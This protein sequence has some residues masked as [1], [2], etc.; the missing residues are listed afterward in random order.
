MSSLETIHLTIHGIKFPCIKFQTII[1][2]VSRKPSV[3]LCNF[4]RLECSN[5]MNESKIAEIYQNEEFVCALKS[6]FF[7]NRN[8]KEIIFG[9]QCTVYCLRSK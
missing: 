1:K 9:I 7:A 8:H 2:F 4:C 5:E 6:F 3:D